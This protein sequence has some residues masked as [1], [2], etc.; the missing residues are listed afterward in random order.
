MIQF[1]DESIVTVIKIAL[2]A[3]QSVMAYYEVPE[4]LEVMHKQ[5]HSPVTLADKASH[6]III[7]E[8][9]SFQVC[10]QRY[11]IVSEEDIK[12]HQNPSSLSTY[13]CVDPL[14]GT[15]EYIARTGEFSINIALIHDH[16]PIF[17]L[18]YSPL[19]NKA[20][21][22][23]NNG[24]AFVFDCADWNAKIYPKKIISHSGCHM[25]IRMMVSRRHDTKKIENFFKSKQQKIAISYFGS[26]LKFTK[27]AMGEADL[28]VRSSGSAEWDN[29][30]GHC[31]I[32]EAGGNVFSLDNFEELT[33]GNGKSYK[34]KA[35]FVVGD[36][37]HS[38]HELLNSWR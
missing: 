19:E 15:K 7:N 13:W 25:P 20:Y 17:G 33:Y 5:D 18:I 23:Y 14:D 8:L 27:I 34:Q 29:A 31:L 28:F 37:S 30:A 22:G 24:G 26:A 1:D 3:S 10:G 4:K 11:P 16:H 9:Q 35:F 38:W 21:V 2:K 12:H 6:E 36:L 32:K